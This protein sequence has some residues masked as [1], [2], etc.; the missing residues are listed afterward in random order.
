MLVSKDDIKTIIKY[1]AKL[2]VKLMVW[3]EICSSD[4]MYL[5]P[6]KAIVLRHDPTTAK[7][8]ITI[9]HELGHA[10]D[11]YNKDSLIICPKV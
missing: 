1:I 5:I 8:L 7:D 11:L 6:T 10:I 4:G 3:P 2:N 9:A